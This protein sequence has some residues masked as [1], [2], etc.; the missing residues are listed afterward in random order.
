MKLI[1]MWLFLLI[2]LPVSLSG[3]ERTAVTGQDDYDMDTVHIFNRGNYLYFNAPV[4]GL[5]HIHFL[6]KG[7]ECVDIASF[8]GGDG[9]LN[10][11]QILS[12]FYGIHEIP[13]Q[14]S[15]PLCINQIT[16]NNWPFI[17][18]D[19]SVYHSDAVLFDS[20]FE[21]MIIAD[22][23]E[24][25]EMLV[26]SNELAYVPSGY[27]K[28][29]F[30]YVH[31]LPY[32]LFKRNIAG[33]LYTQWFRLDHCRNNPVYQALRYASRGV[34]MGLKEAERSI[35]KGSQ[36]AAESVEIGHK[37][38]SYG[39]NIAIENSTSSIGRSIYNESKMFYRP[40]RIFEDMSDLVFEEKAI[41][42]GAGVTVYT[43]FFKS[44][45][46]K[47]N[48]FLVHGNG[49]NVSTYKDMTKTLVAGN[50]NVYVVDW[51]GYGK[52]TGYPEYK[53]VLMDTEA[54][55]DDFISQV[56]SDSLK[57]IVYGMSLGGQIA[58]KLVSDRQHDVD[59]LIL[60]GSLSSAQNLA[61][62]FMPAGFIRNSMEK[63][64]SLFNQDYVAERDIK[65][66]VNVPKL[67][68]HSETDQV[69][70]F[71][72]GERIFENAGEPK[73][74]WKTNTD[75]IMTLVELP[76]ETIRKIDDLLFLTI[77]GTF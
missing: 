1:F 65:D 38:T 13:L 32:I 15:A 43:Y 31:N 29:E 34:E 16:W 20:Y 30:V 46:P 27:A 5:P 48:I 70:L 57:K 26:V 74:F 37:Q 72:H 28:F 52:S 54:A 67:I 10:V 73:F 60:D 4:L 59:A 53:G 39:A 17:Q 71:Y 19:T 42:V 18:P 75:H 64:T 36:R 63:N 66:I 69:V 12:N 49:G 35:E 22:I 7:I 23:D 55:F 44:K 68:I 33:V 50:Y 76:D 21:D 47:A 58:T 77:R 51:R 9:A 11:D 45:M 3:E 24:N 61:A 62:D 41:D 14:A 56:G 25:K 6:G 8:S 40:S 2:I